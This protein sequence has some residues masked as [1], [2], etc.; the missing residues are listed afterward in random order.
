MVMNVNLEARVFHVGRVI[1]DCG[2][3]VWAR[4]ADGTRFLGN[5]TFT[6]RALSYILHRLRRISF[7][8]L[9]QEVLSRMGKEKELI[10]NYESKEVTIFGIILTGE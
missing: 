2:I 3:A 1:Y 6:W 5:N 9:L 7:P 4:F 10:K 8:I